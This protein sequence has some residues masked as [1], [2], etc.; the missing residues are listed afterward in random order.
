MAR[1]YDYL[2]ASRCNN[3][4]NRG[5]NDFEDAWHW[6]WLTRVTTGPAPLAI[7]DLRYILAVQN[8]NGVEMFGMTDNEDIDPTQPGTPT[9]WWIDESSGTPTIVA[10]PVGDVTLRVRYTS[11]SAPLTADTDTPTLPVS[12]HQLWIDL[13]QIHAY[14]E[15]D[16]YAAA[17]QL[18]QLTRQDLQ[19]AVEQYETRNRM[20]SMTILIRAGSE[21]E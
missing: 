14:K 18:T 20:N 11:A 5:L 6:P 3:M 8:D 4:L 16:N 19:S 7:P 2:A 12:F 17:A 13:A 15:T 9:D 21:D 1:G 10:W